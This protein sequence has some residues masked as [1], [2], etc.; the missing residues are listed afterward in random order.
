MSE[1]QELIDRCAKMS[2]LLGLVTGGLL[3][4]LRDTAIPNYQKEPM[5]E[6]LTRVTNGIEELYYKE[7]SK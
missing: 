5:L 1:H 2:F 4:F 3:E 6:L 7:E